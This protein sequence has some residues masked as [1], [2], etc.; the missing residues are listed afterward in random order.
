MKSK[1]FVT[2]KNIIVLLIVVFGLAASLPTLAAHAAPMS[3]VLAQEPLP[4]P[5]A[6]LFT[7]FKNLTGVAVFIS[8][9]IN[10]LK[11]MG[12]IRNGDAPAWSV[13]F[14]LAGMILLF[15]LQLAGRADLVPVLDAQASGLSQVL[16]VIIA[17]VY[18]IFVTKLTHENALSGMPL[19]GKSFSR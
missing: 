2:G 5:T 6:D 16:T 3:G 4:D 13:G 1:N 17:F 8:A 14:N 12:I 18:Q 10:A 7:A 15:G 9:L 11:T 19:I